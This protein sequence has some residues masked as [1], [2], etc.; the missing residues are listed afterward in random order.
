MANRHGNN[1]K[2]KYP[3]YLIE[4]WPNDPYS[5]SIITIIIVTFRK[6]QMVIHI[7][8]NQKIKKPDWIWSTEAKPNRKE[9]FFSMQLISQESPAVK[10]NYLEGNGPE[11]LIHK[12]LL[13]ILTESRILWGREEINLL[14]HA[15]CSNSPSI[16][17]LVVFFWQ[18]ELF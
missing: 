17:F 3:G 18:T 14:V 1:N 7:W 5:R 13:L 9:R 12:G 4:K 6:E 8:V 16:F 11:W 10:I 2:I 15:C